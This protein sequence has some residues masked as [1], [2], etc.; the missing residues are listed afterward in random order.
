MNGL[1]SDSF[2]G[3]SI[4]STGLGFLGSGLGLEQLTRFIQGLIRYRDWYIKDDIEM[5]KFLILLFNR[6]LLL[7]SL[8]IRHSAKVL[9]LFIF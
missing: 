4:F 5:Y 9:F 1:G 2:L 6:N 7:G 3:S 8:E